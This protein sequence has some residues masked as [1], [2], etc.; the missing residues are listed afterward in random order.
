M[1]DRLAAGSPRGLGAASE[2]VSEALH[3]TDAALFVSGLVD[4]LRDPRPV[5]QNRAARAL[6]KIQAEHPQSLNPFAKRL[7]R[8]TLAR[9]DL[10]ARWNLLI[11]CGNLPL[12]GTDRALA[13]D[14]MFDSLRGGSALER[15]FAM[16]ALVNFAAGDRALLERVKP[17]VCAALR[18]PSAAVRA[19]ARKLLP[20]V[21]G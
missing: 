3:T 4:T 18:N 11:V 10:R 17:I 19:R 9:S 2:I 15:T 14:L 20:L 8:A 21:K 12:R 6:K 16:Q 5:V 13:I 1:G 7:L